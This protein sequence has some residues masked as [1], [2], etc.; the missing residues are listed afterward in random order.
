M[1]REARS[2]LGKRLEGRRPQGVPLR[3]Q[4]RRGTRPE[5]GCREAKRLEAQV[6]ELLAL[7]GNKKRKLPLAVRC[8]RVLAT[9]TDPSWD[10]AML[11]TREHLRT[12]MRQ[13]SLLLNREFR[14][15]E[16]RDE[17]V[18]TA[19]AVIFPAPAPSHSPRQSHREK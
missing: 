11:N 4:R 10:E 19:A 1:R 6:E 9:P 2:Q 17:K 18:E 12:A 7:A 8:D 13:L 16:K 5:A 14:V 3:A 15:S